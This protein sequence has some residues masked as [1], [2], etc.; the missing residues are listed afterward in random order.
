[1]RGVCA[2]AKNSA[3]ISIGVGDDEPQS[4]WPPNPEAYTMRSS[5]LSQR[6]VVTLMTMTEGACSQ[7][8]R[9]I[10]AT[11]FSHAKLEQGFGAKS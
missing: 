6:L 10:Q 5:N 11:S 9:L 8:L 2:F 1:M 3:K 7:R 4:A